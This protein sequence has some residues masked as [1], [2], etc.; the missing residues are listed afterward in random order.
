[1][2]AEYYGIPF[3]EPPTH[4]FDFQL[5]CRAAMAARRLGVGPA[6]GWRLCQ[7]VY[8]SAI[9]PLDENVCRRIAQ[10]V[11]LSSADF[12]SA[13]AD[14]ETEHQLLESALEAH[15]RGA[16]GVPTFFIGDQMFWGN[17]RIVL[18]R[19]FLTASRSS[20]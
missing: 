11:G 12:R 20:P 5:L 16:F 4:D 13:L 8:G 6:Y 3:R 2:W 10:E 15:R 1:M 9:W 19:H 7:A 17:D 14:P 18:L